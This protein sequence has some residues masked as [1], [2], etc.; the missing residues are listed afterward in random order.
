MDEVGDL[1][2]ARKQREAWE[3][4]AEAALMAGG[5][6]LEE[7]RERAKAL[8]VAGWKTVTPEEAAMDELKHR[9]WSAGV[10][11]EVPVRVG[12]AKFVVLDVGL[13]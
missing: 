1:A 12:Q 4:A 6:I 10:A 8:A 13:E 5:M 11:D 7:A 3:S 9:G 2:A